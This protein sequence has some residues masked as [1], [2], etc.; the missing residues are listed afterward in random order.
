MDDQSLKM[1]K[2]YM[3]LDFHYKSF[4]DRLIIAN[5][6]KGAQTIIEKLLERGE[7]VLSDVQKVEKEDGAIGRKAPTRT[8]PVMCIARCFDNSSGQYADSPRILT[9]DSP[10]E[11]EYWTAFDILAR[12]S[13]TV[14][15]YATETVP[16]S[17]DPDYRILNEFRLDDDNLANKINAISK[18]R[19][20]K[21]IGDT[22]SKRNTGDMTGLDD[23]DTD[24]KDKD[25]DA[26]GPGGLKYV[27]SWIRV[28]PNY[29]VKKKQKDP[30]NAPRL[31]LDLDVM[32]YIIGGTLS[33]VILEMFPAA[34]V[35]DPSLQYYF[36]QMKNILI[37]LEV[38]CKSDSTKNPPESTKPQ[39]GRVIVDIKW[40]SEVA[41]FPFQKGDIKIKN[42]SVIR[43]RK[44]PW[45][46]CVAAIFLL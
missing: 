46:E 33:D 24:K 6:G 5:F 37:G 1:C 4:T 34:S 19:D 32:P 44:Y 16:A 28:V 15:K 7:V 27:R 21:E 36:P 13:A 41:K 3:A 10:D 22:K 25:K 8:K 31:H 39:R 45:V 29:E 26:K 35:I 12:N 18:K 17:F 20:P 2:G 38:N 43:Y 23:Q 40:P 11:G 30:E 14:R 9:H 42:C